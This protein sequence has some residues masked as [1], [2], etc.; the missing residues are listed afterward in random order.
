[1]VFYILY[2]VL[3]LRLGLK[4][5]YFFSTDYCIL[6]TI[7]SRI[8]SLALALP[9]RA[10]APDSAI[11]SGVVSSLG[12]QAEAHENHSTFKRAT[13]RRCHGIIPAEIPIVKSC[14]SIVKGTVLKGLPPKK[15][16][17]IWTTTVIK[18]M[19]MNQ[20]LFISP[21]N[22]LYSLSLILR[23][24]NWLKTWSHTNRLK[25]IVYKMVFSVG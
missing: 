8:E 15:M 9:E 5:F 24:L 6:L 16:T 7:A 18:A 23:A 21:E 2:R 17:Q 1:M 10:T 11:S 20:Q 13:Q 14:W 4:S 19:A 12:T 3:Q 22:T 25:I